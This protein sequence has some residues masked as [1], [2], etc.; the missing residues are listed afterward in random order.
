MA[1]EH[2]YDLDIQWTGNRGEGTASYR[3][4]DRSHTIKAHGK[5]P[6]E[7]SSDPSFRGDKTKY[8][9]E[10]LLVASLS[11]CHM[12]W[13]LHLCAVNGVVVTDYRDEAVGVMLVSD[14]GDGMFKE[15]ILKPTVT[16][17]QSDMIEKLE[18]IHT[19]ANKKCFIAKSVNFPVHHL[20]EAMV[21]ST[22]D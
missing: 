18:A 5:V 3:T 17:T 10:E 8:N 12:L 1:K 16:V 22:A 11:S 9:P 14:D 7:A 2:H 20:P 21:K 15:V 6:I 13:V 19:E 4:Y